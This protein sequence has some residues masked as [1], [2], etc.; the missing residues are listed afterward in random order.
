[1]TSSTTPGPSPA[2][3]GIALA[4]VTAMASATLAM[5]APAGA[6]PLAN[7]FAAG[8]VELLNLASGAAS[9]QNDGTDTTIH[10]VAGA[11]ADVKKVRFEYRT[12]A[13]PWTPIATADPVAGAFSATF[14]PPG[15]ILGGNVDYRVVGLDAQGADIPGAEDIVTGVVTGAGSTAVNLAATPGQALGAFEQPYGPAGSKTLV[16]V[17]G[18]TSDVSGAPNVTVGEPTLGNPLTPADKYGTPANGVRTFSGVADLTGYVFDTPVA[19]AVAVDEAVIY[20]EAQSDDAEPVALYKQA[21]TTVNAAATNALLPTGDNT[22]ITVTVLDQFDKPVA[23]ARVFTDSADADA[24]TKFTDSNGEAVFTGFTGSQAGTVHTFHVD[25]TADVAYNAGDDFLRPVTVTSYTPQVASLAVE[26]KTE[27]GTAFDRNEHTAGDIKVTAKDQNNN[28]I[29]V[30]AV[31]GL[32]SVTTFGTTPTTT[33][34]PAMVDPVTGA[35][36]LP[37]AA[38]DGT[39]TLNT[40]V[41]KNGTPGQQA[42]DL[43]AAALVVKVGEAKVT[44]VD[45]DNYIQAPYGNSSTFI[46][47]VALADGT[48]LAGRVVNLVLNPGAGDVTVSNTQPT[49][50]VKNTATTATAT[51]AADGTVKVTL[52]DPVTT[53]QVKDLGVLLDATAAPLGLVAADV[54]DLEIDFLNVTANQ[55]TF[56]TGTQLID[57][58]NNNATAPV[59]TPGRP[60]SYTLTVTNADGDALDNTAVTLTLDH[61]YFTTYAAAASALVPEVAAAEGGLVGA[62]KNEGMT[63]NLT[64]DADGKVKVT[65]VV[66]RDAALDDDGAVDVKITATAGAATA[67]KTLAV[68]SRDALNPGAVTVTASPASTT[69]P[70]TLPKARAGK[71]VWFDVVATDQFG[72]RIAA[73]VALADNS[74]TDAATV[75]PASTTGLF[76]GGTTTVYATSTAAAAQTVSG[77]WDDA[78]T[79]TWTDT[80]INTVG[81]QAGFKA[82]TKD[83][84]GSAAAIDWY[85]V[86]YATSTLAMTSDAVEGANESGKVITATYS[87][88]DQNGAPIDGVTV[89]FFRGDEVQS[90]K[91]TDAAGK[92]T[93]AFQGTEGAVTVTAL[94][95]DAAGDPITVS[96]RSITVQ[97]GEDTT[98]EPTPDPKAIIA[99]L[100]GR[101]LKDGSNMLRVDVADADATGAAVRVYR[102]GADGLVLVA[103]GTLANGKA[104]F[105]VKDLNGKKANKYFAMVGATELTAKTRTAGVIVR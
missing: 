74:G 68:S 105:K 16:R 42:G 15:A 87:A 35:V 2:R 73:P 98:E 92:A 13:N 83:V 71:K 93:F 72:N 30:G 81:F 75:L 100:T 14:A 94:V 25:T 11:A 24:D 62:W 82:G 47:K 17:A 43:S 48:V 60:V 79:T 80:D 9:T 90:T 34:Y 33:T 50:T 55:V 10:L 91:T 5:A 57:N 103:R 65:V 49:G 45:A 8:T 56:D 38:P 1:M 64:T 32:W 21:I 44:W 41:E 66:G 20:A 18:T 96:S 89:T 37:A 36:D 86:D 69:N 97:F 104:Q 28:T 51:S 59:A 39:Y 99:T 23:G 102:K 40:W 77:L 29:A 101:N 78:T 6:E 85:A 84:S 4:A 46:G 67:A 61:G 88:V 19:P 26:T 27:L 63:K 53:P 31:Q 12:G 22:P 58:D 70:T 76:T 7:S 3:R 95:F 52:T 54:T